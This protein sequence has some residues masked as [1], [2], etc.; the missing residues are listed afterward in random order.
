MVFENYES[1]YLIGEVGTLGVHGLVSE[2]QAL[3]AAATAWTPHWGHSDG[4]VYRESIDATW[5]SAL[6]KIEAAIGTAPENPEGLAKAELTAIEATLLAEFVH[7]AKIPAEVAATFDSAFE[8][9]AFQITKGWTRVMAQVVHS[10]TDEEFKDFKKYV[11]EHVAW[12][13]KERTRKE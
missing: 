9:G 7:T 6:K 1:Y 2:W 4:R 10:M 5:Q 13:A 11:S 3:H 12:L 8:G